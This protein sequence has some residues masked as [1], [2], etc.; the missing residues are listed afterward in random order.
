MYLNNLQSVSPAIKITQSIGSPVNINNYYRFSNEIFNGTLM[1][2]NW[3]AEISTWELTTSI[4]GLYQRHYSNYIGNIFDLKARLIV[5]KCKFNPVELSNIKL[6][7]R[8]IIR[9]KKYTIN[10][11]KCDLITG[12]VDMELLSDYR[13]IGQVTI[14]AR[15]SFEDNYQVPAEE[16]TFEMLVLMTDS[17]EVFPVE[18]DVD[19]IRYDEDAITENS[20]L[21]ITV[22]ENTTGLERTG[23]VNLIYDDKGL[24]QIPITQNA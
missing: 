9:D 11:M 15:Y 1:S 12:E 20:I 22:E 18:S 8:I 23:Y 24:I 3:G 6:N 2:L 19:W 13:T 14:G 10:S 21:N 17:V 7:D 16:S 5:V 4:N